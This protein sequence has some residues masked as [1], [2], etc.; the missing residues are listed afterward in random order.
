MNI[1]LQLPRFNWPG[2]PVEIGPRLLD[3]ARTAEDAG[4]ASLWVMD[5]FFQMEMIG[6]P[7]SPML[8][9]YTT[10]GYIAGVTRRSF[11]TRTDT[12]AMK[13]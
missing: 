12:G 9:A 10:L 2:G 5:H 11:K 13:P 6:G 7:D 3:I 8:E 1:G 4:F